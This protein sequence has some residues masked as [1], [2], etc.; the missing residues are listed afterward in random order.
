MKKV[1][2]VLSLSMAA[3]AAMS[4]LTILTGE[5]SAQQMFSFAICFTSTVLF[6]VVVPKTA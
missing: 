3:L 2:S 6:Y 1:R 4:A 5:N